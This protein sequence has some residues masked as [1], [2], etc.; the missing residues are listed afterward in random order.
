MPQGLCDVL[1][2]SGLKPMNDDWGAS[3][4][5][6]AQTHSTMGKRSCERSPV[7]VTKPRTSHSRIIAC[8]PRLRQDRSCGVLVGGKRGCRDVKHTMS[9]L[10]ESSQSFLFYTG[11]GAEM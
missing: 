8:I 9:C 10:Q 3:G 4:V 2:C 5:L 6:A 1:V 11:S 7:T